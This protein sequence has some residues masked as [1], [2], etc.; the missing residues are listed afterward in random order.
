MY[1]L[2]G[3]TPGQHI[4]ISYIVDIDVLGEFSVVYILGSE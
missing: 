3:R 2:L 4:P 1:L